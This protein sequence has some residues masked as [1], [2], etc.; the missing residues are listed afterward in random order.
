MVI[1]LRLE[2]GSIQYMLLDYISVLPLKSEICHDAN[3]DATGGTRDCHN[4]PPVP[5]VTTKLASWW[6]SDFSVCNHQTF[7]PSNKVDLDMTQSS[8]TVWVHIFIKCMNASITQACNYHTINLIHIPHIPIRSTLHYKS[9]PM[10]KCQ[11]L[12]YSPL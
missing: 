7:V 1:S 12:S 8:S 11:I 4:E 10:N 5:S 9:A 2:Y 6:L 3:F